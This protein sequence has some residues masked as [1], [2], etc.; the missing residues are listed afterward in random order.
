MLGLAF[1][2]Q[3]RKDRYIDLKQYDLTIYDRNFAGIEIAEFLTALLQRLKPVN[4]NQR[5]VQLPWF[6]R[7]NIQNKIR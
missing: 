3:I 2:H 1:S 4:V 6:K 7:Q 5:V